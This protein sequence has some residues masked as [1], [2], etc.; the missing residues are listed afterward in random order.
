MLHLHDQNLTFHILIRPIQVC[1]RKV[2]LL[3]LYHIL[4]RFQYA[5]PDG[6]RCELIDGVMYEFNA[7]TLV[8]Q[9]IISDI[10]AQMSICAEGHDQRRYM[11]SGLQQDPRL[12]KLVPEIAKAGTVHLLNSPCF[13]SSVKLDHEISIYR[14]LF[15]TSASPAATP[16]R[17]PTA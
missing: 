15:I 3:T 10:S 9:S 2:F 4:K 14:S 7:P 5:L 16:L 8:H 6:V 12:I 1:S 13:N 11:R 17:G